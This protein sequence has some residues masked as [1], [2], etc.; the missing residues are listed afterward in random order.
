MRT[1]ITDP[2][3]NFEGEL[4]DRALAALRRETGLPA[5]VVQREPVLANKYRPDALIAIE[6]GHEQRE[7]LVEIKA[8]DRIELLG[9]VRALWPATAQPP[10][11]LV[12]PYITPTLATKC[13]ELRLFFVDAA[14]NAYLDL[15]GL[16][17]QIV[18]NKRAPEDEPL[19]T[20][21]INNPAALKTIFALLCRPEL[22]N[23]TYRDIATAA[24]VALGT[25]GPVIKELEAKKYVATFGA[26]MVRRRLLDEGRL[27]KDW[28]GF[29]A[30][31]LRPKL[32]PR[33]FKAPDRAWI[34][35]TDLNLHGAYWGGEVAAQRLAN[36][37]VPEHAIIY[38]RTAP[39]LLLTEN[40]LRPDVNGEIELLDVFWNPDQ[41][42][43]EPGLVPVVLTYADLINTTDGRNIEVANLIYEEYIA[44]TLHPGKQQ[45]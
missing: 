6:A 13:R 44:P 14:G 40:R 9:H 27:V 43:H 31:A 8:V 3:R 45:G 7:L 33:R 36:F 24:R 26:T 42:P 5:V 1:A 11:V 30:A 22:L 41:L 17:V 19:D 2:A 28:A 4:L 20:G 37:V 18:G 35:R 29:Y 15:P 32:T 34:Q 10:L 16:H 21:R 23:A 38:T 39:T 25:V 12:A